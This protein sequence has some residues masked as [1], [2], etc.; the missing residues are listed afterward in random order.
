MKQRYPSQGGR[1][2]P[3]LKD[4]VMKVVVAYSDRLRRENNE[5]WCKALEEAGS[6]HRTCKQTYSK[7][8]ANTDNFATFAAQLTQ[9]V[10]DKNYELSVGELQELVDGGNYNITVDE[11]NA[12]KT[13]VKEIKARYGDNQPVFEAYSQFYPR[14]N[15]NSLFKENAKASTHNSKA[16]TYTGIFV[17]FLVKIMLP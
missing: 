5:A 17:P 2:M 10:G 13:R 7:M 3:D 8:P 15:F 16:S 9:A 1:G 6:D 14:V 11:M 12:L 4:T